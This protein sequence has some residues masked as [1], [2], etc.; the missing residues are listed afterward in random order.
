M[1]NKTLVS[2]VM[3]TYGHENF[4][5]QAIEGVL[6]QEFSA[7]IELIIA[8]DCSPDGTDGVIKT[9]IENHP[10]GAW[11]KY[12]N[13]PVN[14]GMMNNF[15]WALKQAKGKYI[16]LC[17]GDDYWIDSLKLQKQIDFLEK[18][19]EY[20]LASTNAYLN[21]QKSKILNSQ[22]IEDFSFN[23]EMQ[24]LKNRCITCTC[25]FRS[26]QFQIDN[27]NNFENLRI[28]DIIIWA[29][30]L[31]NNGLGF[32]LNENTSV[33]REH[34]GGNYSQNNHKENT[35]N[36]LNVYYGLLRSSMFNFNERKIIKHK[37]QLIWY[38]VL[39]SRNWFKV[40]NSFLNV[41]RNLDILSFKSIVLT[42]KSVIRFLDKKMTRK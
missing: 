16:A 40:E 22:I 10:R 15:I 25:V 37:L 4:I 31:R 26:N 42:L 12:T 8:N 41:L 5:Q 9:I 6:M 35:I 18:N 7:E 38:D 33:Y 11:I 21:H 39:H 14:M 34:Y 28:G 23:Y 3:I 29:L 17:D 27:L 36:E 19:K 20:N 13:H 2:V 32:F 1:N 24:I 30:V